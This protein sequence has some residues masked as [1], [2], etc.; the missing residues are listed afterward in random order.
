MPRRPTLVLLAS[1]ACV[2]AGCAHDPENVLHVIAE[3]APGLQRSARV[4]YRGV[5]V[6]RVKQ[7]YFT[8]TGVRID[9]VL[10]RRDV[11]IRTQD[12]VRISPLGPFGAAVV[13]IQP[14][15]LTAPLIAHGATLPRVQPES[16]VAMPVAV[17]R[18]LVRSLGLAADTAP[19]PAPAADTATTR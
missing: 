12:T 8:S 5:E 4:Q 13:D 18:S 1:A 16:T 6:G 17:W 2:A 7:V 10:D 11:P 15:A 14:G 3:R 9:I 19:P